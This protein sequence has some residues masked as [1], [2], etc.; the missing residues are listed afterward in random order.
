MC[1]DQP[2]CFHNI[3]LTTESNQYLTNCQQHETIKI[4]RG[5]FKLLPHDFLISN[6]LLWFFH[7][8]KFSIACWSLISWMIFRLHSQQDF[9]FSKQ[10]FRFTKSCFSHW[11][12]MQFLLNEYVKTLKNLDFLHLSFLYL[13]CNSITF[14]FIQLNFCWFI[15]ESVIAPCFFHATVVLCYY[16]A[17]P[18]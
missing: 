6:F 1:C 14:W 16:S 3:K 9:Y 10:D 5:C 13:N 18:H 2:S 12:F 8:F 4:K 15:H 11:I 17:F 7:V